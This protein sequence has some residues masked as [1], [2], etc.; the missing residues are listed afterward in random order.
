ML[1][2]VTNG[3]LKTYEEMTSYGRYLLTGDPKPGKYSVDEL[4]HMGIIG[5]YKE[6]KHDND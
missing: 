1:K 4:K 2:W 5:I 6:E 3:D